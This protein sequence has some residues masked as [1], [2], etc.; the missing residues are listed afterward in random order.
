MLRLVFE[1]VMVIAVVSCLFFMMKLGQVDNSLEE[2][3]ED[4]KDDSEKS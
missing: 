2:T 1:A 4:T 3:S